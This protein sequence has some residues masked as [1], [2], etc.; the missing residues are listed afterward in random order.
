[1]SNPIAVV[2]GVSSFLGMHLVQAY[3]D[4]GYEV[5]GLSHRPIEALDPL[6]RARRERIRP[7]LAE[8]GALDLLDA[9]SVRERVVSLRPEV[10]VQQ[11]GVGADY[12]SEAY[13]MRKAHELN[14]MA[15]DGL[16]RAC[17]EAGTKILVTGSSMEYGGAA[18]PQNE[19]DPCWP[20]TPYGLSRLTA[21]L[22][23]R[24]LANLYSVPARVA[25]VFAMCGELDSPDKFVARV[26][27]Q[28]MA[29]E[30]VSVAPHI[31]RDLCD[32]KDVAE[33]FVR[34]TLA[35]RSGPMFDVFN[36][37]RGEASNLHEVASDCARL[38]GCDERLVRESAGMARPNE[39]L[40]IAGDNRKVQ[41]ETGWSPHP[42]IDA[43]AR[44]AK[45][46]RD[47]VPARVAP[48]LEA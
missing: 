9:E 32:A 46:E 17:A 4:A 21:T 7:L 45:A 23:T 14:V 37:S 24:Q 28:L 5:V 26:L 15:L 40:V 12:S 22:R 30:A 10:F 43:L 8:D 2:S 35:M 29:G 11:A 13:D 38:L 47:A 41:Q 19:V 18:S 42:L 34:L 31:S 39:P 1:M 25:R 33:G 44:M 6:R 20:H 36:L 48:R 27:S 3:A 16:F